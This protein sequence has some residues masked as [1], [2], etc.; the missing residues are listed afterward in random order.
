M[1][2]QVRVEAP[3]YGL[4][5]VI[6]LRRRTNRLMCGVP[7]TTA[8]NGSTRIVRDMR[9]LH[10]SIRCRSPHYFTF[11]KV[12]RM[13]KTL[14]PGGS[15]RAR[16][17]HAQNQGAEVEQPH[18]GTRFLAPLGVCGLPVRSRLGAKLRLVLG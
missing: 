5:R 4:P 13:Q 1:R 6:V 9:N 15:T 7:N 11:V 10:P 3:L 12:P 17:Q 8:A 2:A 14:V 18:R 16:R